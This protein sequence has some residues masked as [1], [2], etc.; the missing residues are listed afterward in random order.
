M[1]KKYKDMYQLQ[2]DQLSACHQGSQSEYH[3]V[4]VIY[5]A[6]L[7]ILSCKLPAK[8]YVHCKGIQSRWQVVRFAH[9]VSEVRPP[10]E[11]FNWNYLC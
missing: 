7:Q 2:D 9:T 10:T 6:F 5:F 4:D 1:E 8:L 11:S 3:M